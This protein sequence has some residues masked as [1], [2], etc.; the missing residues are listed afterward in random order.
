MREADPMPF[1]QIY[2]TTLRDGTQSEGFTLSAHSKIRLAQ[3]LDDLGV[4]FIEGGWP[5]S[6]PKDAEFFE[7]ARDLEWRTALIA[8]FGSTCRVKG[9]PEDDANIHALIDSQAP[10]CTIFGK[11]WTLHVTDVLL[12]TLDDNLR[13]I[14]QSVAHL[15]A[16]GRRV[17]YDA[18]HFFDGY[19]A[20]PLYALETLK[21]AIRGGAET[22]VLC[23][24]NGGTMP[25]DVER[26]IAEMRQAV[27]HPFG[28]HTHNDSECAVINALL[29]VRQGATQVQGTI[30]GVGER[31]GNANLCSIMANLELKMGRQCLPEGRL[32]RL[33]EISHVVDEVANITPNDHLPYVGKS[34]FAHKGGV[35][36]AAMRRSEQSYQHVAPERVGNRMRVVVS[37]LSGRANI[38]SKAEE[39][40]VDVA[41]VADV[42][43]VLNDVKELEAR[44]FSF[45]AAEASVAMML[46]RQQPG[47]Q[48]PF[49]LID[50]LVN[51]EHRQ[52]R[53]TF[54]EAMVKVRVN[55]EVLHTAA[56]GNG[57]VNA[58]DIALRKALLGHFPEIASFQLAD[59]KVRI[60]DGQDGTEA[61]TRVLI[62]TRSNTRTWSTVGA[63]ANIIE[64]S[65][66]ALVD[67][68][69]Y[70]LSLVH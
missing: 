15:R 37:A 28:I 20:D 52:G 66:Q 70:G 33:Y 49:E 30:N 35:H 63:S 56:E 17:I 60:L 59:Y 48:A 61:I 32:H 19:R 45:E 1:I 40:G 26:I 23:D 34:A 58:L 69:E 4:A 3:R 27:D 62:D 42:V 22:L 54:A 31:C 14:E 57:P 2:D 24:T 50:F 39:H 13:I 36:V 68:I 7:R 12:T 8:A 11:T 9:G 64:A 67:A 47:Y 21:A 43:G 29:A 5:G 18:E 6:N 51:V 25:W 44:G 53:G 65:W 41:S 46:K 16:A 38:L 55:D 10:V